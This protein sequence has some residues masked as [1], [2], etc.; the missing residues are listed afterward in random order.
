MLKSRYGGICV[1]QMK[2]EQNAPQNTVK[3]VHMDGKRANSIQML[4]FS[5]CNIHF[6]RLSSMSNCASRFGCEIWH[7][8]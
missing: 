2:E 5:K 3:G 7:V 1:M 8:V 4:S 6:R